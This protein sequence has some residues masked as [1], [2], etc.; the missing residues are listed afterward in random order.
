[1]KRRALCSWG[2][3]ALATS[4]MAQTPARKPAAA[5]NWRLV[6]NE[7]VTGETNFFLL[8]NRYQPLADFVTAQIKG[9][10]IGIEPMVDIQRFM[11]VAQAQPRPELVFGKS[12]NQLAKISTLGERVEDTFLVDG[13]ELQQNRQQIEIETELLE[14]LGA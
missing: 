5:G 10:S 1:M 8:T 6:I 9:R 2:L 4:A 13:P 14:A 11:A 12:V 3:A 7:A